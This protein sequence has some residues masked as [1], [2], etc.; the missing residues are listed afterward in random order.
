MRFLIVF[1]I[2][3]LA[4]FNDS[5]SKCRIKKITNLVTNHTLEYFYNSKGLIV[6]DKDLGGNNISYQYINN[7]IIKTYS[8][9]GHTNADTIFLNKKGLIEE[10]HETDGI[11][12]KYKF[13]RDSFLEESQ[14]L[15]RGYEGTD[16]RFEIV[17]GNVKMELVKDGK[18][19]KFDVTYYEYYPNTKN[20]IG[21]ENMGMPFMGKNS[22]N[23][24]K[25]TIR[26]LETDTAVIFTYYHFD[27]MGKVTIKSRY[28]NGLLIDSMGYT[29]Y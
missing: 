11:V 8:V 13:T 16:S 15:N 23:L 1:F 4:S 20:T 27:Q 19:N 24:E 9:G 22:V 5:D 29:Y 2:I 3:C 7:T 18:G 28:R 21:V 14:S 12:H 26:I 25:K 10:A 6:Q 17:K